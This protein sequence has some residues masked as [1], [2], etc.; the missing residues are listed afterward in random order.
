MTRR[1]NAAMLKLWLEQSMAARARPEVANGKRW[2]KPGDLR[3]VSHMQGMAALLAREAEAL[4][5]GAGECAHHEGRVDGACPYCSRLWSESKL[6]EREDQEVAEP[7]EGGD[8]V[9]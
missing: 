7:P 8:E 1:T 9:W 4:S 5:R 2:S 3:D 6:D